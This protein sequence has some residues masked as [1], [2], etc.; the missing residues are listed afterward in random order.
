KLAYLD[1]SRCRGDDA[2]RRHVCGHVP[3]RAHRTSMAGVLL[4]L[5]YTADDGSV[6][7]VPQPTNLGRVRGLDLFHRF[8]VV[9][10]YRTYSR[11]GYAAGSRQVPHYEDGLWST[12]DGMARIRAPL[13]SLRD[14]ISAS[15][16]TLD[17]AGS[18]R[19]HRGELGFRGIG[20]SG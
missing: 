15:R 18:F 4:A 17:A 8:T 14:C 20:N 2:V 6:A 9:L 3:A 13:G 19:A 16:G 1:Q 5:S 12:G 7:A 11:F 10:V